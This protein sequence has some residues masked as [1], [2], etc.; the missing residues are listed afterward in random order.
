MA[1]AAAAAEKQRSNQVSFQAVASLLDALD[2]PLLVSDRAGLIIFTNLHAQNALNPLAWSAKP[3]PNLFR[4]ILNADGKE[5]LSQLER[6]KQDVL[7]PIEA[8]QGKAVARILQAPAR[9][10]IRCRLGMAM[11]A[12]PRGGPS[13]AQRRSWP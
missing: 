7:L 8:G 11:K 12:E 10:A 1:K 13:R 3:D 5:I 4:D 2:R 9:A 6:G